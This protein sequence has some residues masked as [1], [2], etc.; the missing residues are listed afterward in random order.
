MSGRSSARATPRECRRGG[1]TFVRYQRAVRPR[2]LGSSSSVGRGSAAS[3]CPRNHPRDPTIAYQLA[4][5]AGARP[6]RI[7]PHRR[8]H[9]ARAGHGP[10][11][12]GLA[13]RS[14]QRHDHHAEETP[15]TG[16]VL[17]NDDNPGEGT[18]VVV[19]PFPTLSASVGTL[20]V[21]PDGDYLFTPA[22]N[23]SGSASTTYNVA[24]DKH[25]RPA[26]INIVV[27]G[28]Q[29]PPVA[30]DDTIAVDRRHADQRHGR[31][32]GQRHRRRRR[33]AHGHE[34]LERHGRLGLGVRRRGHVH[35]RRRPLRRRHGQLRLHDLGRQRRVG[36]GPRDC[37]HHLRQRRSPR[38]QRHRSRDRGHRPRHR[39]RG[40]RGQRHRHRGRCPPG[41]RRLEP[42]RRQRLPRRGRRHLHPR[43]RP[44]RHG[45]RGLHVHGQRR[46]RRHGQRP[47]LDRPR[48]HGRRPRRQRRHRHG[49]RGLGRHRR[50]RRP[51][52]Q[53]QRSRRRHAHRHRRLERHGRLGRPDRWRRHLHARRRRVRR[54]LRRLRLHRSTTATATRTRR[55]PRWTSPA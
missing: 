15:A 22:A 4:P 16:N 52:G 13:P 31:H 11:G 41:V 10:R 51:P 14:A 6:G 26:T 40:P 25:T 27:T 37:E 45:R 48:L 44:V 36:L 23:F 1:R 47:R 5:R 34:R 9:P 35:A 24:N 54:R 50:H 3:A 53:R 29:D 2:T 55:T 42:E 39:G 32:Q 38:G 12:P 28:T 46:E 7:R 18:L 21:D 30:N 20:T 19:A 43:R 49:G 17:A 8:R 33:H